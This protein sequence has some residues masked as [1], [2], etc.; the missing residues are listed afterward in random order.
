MPGTDHASIATEA[1]VVAAMR[2]AL[3]VANAEDIALTEADLSQMVRLI[4]GLDPAGMPSMAQDRI[5][6]RKTEVEEFSG[7][8]CCLAARHD[9]QVPQNE[10]LY[11]RIRE[12]EAGW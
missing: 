9:I 10:W 3:A 5:N 4:E 12:I 7:T 11:T 1:K 6:R 8:I 2:E